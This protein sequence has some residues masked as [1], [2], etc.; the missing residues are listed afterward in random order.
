MQSVSRRDFLKLGGVALARALLPQLPQPALAYTPDSENFSAPPASLGRIISW[1]QIVRQEPSQTSERIGTHYRN[2]VIP[3][4]AAVTGE[5]P[6]PS[7]PTWYQTQDGFIHSGYVQPV[8]NKPDLR[9]R[10][11][12]PSPGFWAQVCVPFTDAKWAPNPDSY[13]AHKLYYGTVYRVVKALQDNAGRWW[14]QIQEGMS[15]S[16]PSVYVLAKTLRYISPTELAPISPGRRDKWIQI[17]LDEQM[18]R[19]YEGNNVV[20][21]QRI[22]SGLGGEMATPR[23]EF[24]VLYKR[25]TRRMKGEFAGDEYDLPGV[26]FTNYVTWSGVAIHGTY[27]HNDYGQRHSHGC[28]NMPPESAKWVFRWTDPQIDYKDYT[29]ETD[30]KNPGTRIVIV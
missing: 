2:E 13:T 21:T 16:I 19:C 30:E 9:I 1:S 24:S 10:R 5:P 27:W 22:A 25:H 20:F 7:N 26:P 28:I 8:E 29:Q 18:L 14:Y 23:G 11:Q 17:N 12:V 3:L 6:W 15:Q 4:Q